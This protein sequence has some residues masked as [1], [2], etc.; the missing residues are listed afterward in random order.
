MNENEHVNNP[1]TTPETE[2]TTETVS[3]ESTP[4]VANEAVAP[5]EEST[6]VDAPT[7]SEETTEEVSVVKTDDV[8]SPAEENINEAPASMEDILPAAAMT[9]KD[10]V[11][12]ALAGAGKWIKRRRYT[13]IAVVLVIVAVIG[14]LYILEERGRIHTGMF[15]GVKK[16]VAAHKTVVNVNKNAITQADLDTSISQLSANAEAQGADLSDPKTKEQMRTQALDMLVNTEL[17]KQEAAKRNITISDDDVN[18]RIEQLKKDVGG[19]EVLKERMKQFNIDE[20]TL[21]RDVKNELTIQ[22]LLDQVFKEKGVTVGEDEIKKFYDQAGG[23]KA[24]LPKISEVHDQIASQIKQNKQQEV[25]TAL[26]EELRKAA[27]IE[28]LQ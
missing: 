6:T 10:K 24:G 7:M 27:T 20:K 14:M 3:T 25:V 13:L 21:R 9:P 15:E 2:S 23:A 22:T 1:E 26:I 11:T 28:M 5:V 17:L 19:D 12:S 18:K 8:D 16:F 4:E